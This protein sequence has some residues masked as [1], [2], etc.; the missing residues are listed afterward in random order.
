VAEALHAGVAQATQ[1]RL[2]GRHAGVFLLVAA[3][4]GLPLIASDF[5]LFRLTNV[6]IYAIALLGL[7]ILAGYN[8]QISLGHGAFYAIGGYAAAILVAHFAVPHWAAVPIAGIACLVA[9]IAFGWPTLRLSGM[10]FAMATFALGAVLPI[11]AKS[12]GVEA[13]TGGGQGLALDQPVVPF[14]LPLSFDQWMYLFTLL[15][16]VLSFASAANLLRGRIG[17]ALVAIRD[18]PIA[19]EA[20]GIHAGYYK[21]AALGISAMYAGIA[22]ALA[23]VA[24]QYVAPGLYGI[25]LSFGFLVGVA[26]GGFATLSGALYGAVFLQIL[27][28]AVGA[29]AG[30]LHTSNVFLIYGITLILVVH[31]MP[32]GVASLIERARARLRCARFSS[33]CPRTSDRPGSMTP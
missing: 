23:A 15:V 11:V 12:R 24:L 30:A 27:L 26:V 32:G 22:G 4:A 2:S 33:P 1:L 21:S 17:R 14:D 10:H 18:H 29:T 5:Q 13:W 31:F 3:A 20:T 8:G 6:L 19:A 16:L 25:F 28:A 9:G 7:N